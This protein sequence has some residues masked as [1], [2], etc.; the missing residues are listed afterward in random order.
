MALANGKCVRHGLRDIGL[1]VLDRADEQ[2]K[3]LQVG[4]QIFNGIRALVE[5]PAWGKCSKYDIT[6]IVQSTSCGFDYT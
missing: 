2:F 6:V 4:S 3:I 1:G 5:N